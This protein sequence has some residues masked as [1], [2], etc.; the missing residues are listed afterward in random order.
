[1]ISAGSTSRMP[2]T[3]LISSACWSAV[4]VDVPEYGVTTES[5]RSYAA[6][7]ASMFFLMYGCSLSACEGSTWNCCTIPGHTRPSRIEDSTSRARPTEGSSQVRSTMLARNSTA[8]IN[9][10]NI[11]MLRAGSTALS[12]V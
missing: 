6:L 12:S 2:G 3:F 10:M 7:V 1:M 8:Q 9:A 4:S 5:S 11:R